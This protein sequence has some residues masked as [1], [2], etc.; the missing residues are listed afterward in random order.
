[1]S[2]LRPTLAPL[3]AYVPTP[4]RPGHRLHLNESPED[5]PEFV[6]RAATER[7]LAIDWSRYPEEAH[8]L[9][10]ELATRDGWTADGVLLGNGSN[11]ILQL[12]VFAT[13]APGDAVVLAAPS[14]SLYTTQAKAAG[15][16]VVEVPL[17]AR[18]GE[19][20]RFDV[21]RLI[22]A[23]NESKAKLLLVT[24]PNNPTGTLL[25]VDEVRALHDGT[26]C[27][28]AVDE[29][30]R[31]FAGQDCAPLLASCPRLVLMRTF[32]KSF[33]AA[34][35]RLGYA[36][37]SAEITR[38]LTKLQMPYNLGALG[39]AVARELLRHPA[40]MQERVASVVAERARMERAFAAIPR[41][42]V[43]PGGANFVVV[44]H[45]ERPAA[46]FAAELSERG[47]LVRD[48]TG[49]AGCGRCL[50]IT[51]GLPAGNDAIIAALQ[52]L[53]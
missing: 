43:E 38:E 46:Q 33:A 9:A 11:E 5:L 6:K 17:R 41:L 14:F 22:A 48:L 19:P 2:L 45:V 51:V 3:K 27:L 29:A 40:V 37:S 7:L 26:D 12:V 24:T 32:S 28:V 42:R 35:L 31:D 16:R 44:E 23:A 53:A 30:Y 20:F 15:A 34:A 1:M 25:S 10:A 52:E 21:P 18:E 49:Y 13:L 50:R 39:G 36:L 4:P 47:I 8:L